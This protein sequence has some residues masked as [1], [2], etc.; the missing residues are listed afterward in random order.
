MNER[1]ITIVEAAFETFSRYG[2][3]RTS[4]SDI[5]QAAGMSRQTLYNAFSN[6]DEI[7]QAT[8]RLFADRAIADIEAR[9]IGVNALG[10]QLDIVFDNIAIKP[11][12]LLRATPNSEDILMGFNVTSQT[13]IKNSAERFRAL[14]EG[15]LAPYEK[16]LM[17]SEISSMGLSDILQTAAS[18]AKSNATD[19]DHLKRMLGTL[20]A[21]TVLPLT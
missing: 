16:Q 2:V 21:W 10:D 17:A 14:I 15:L 20:K 8:I 18:T 9:L 4:M 7:L 1:E 12:V 3:K 11:F 6:K 19:I 13:E 5:A